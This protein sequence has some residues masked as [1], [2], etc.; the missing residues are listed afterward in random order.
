MA[1]SLQSKIV[2][3]PRFELELDE[4]EEIQL[5]G[6]RHW[7]ELVQSS[8]LFLVGFL[9][10]GGLALYRSVG[11][12]FIAPNVAEPGQWDLFSVT[13][14]ALVVVLAFLWYRESNLKVPRKK[15]AVRL[16]PLYGFVIALLLLA[17]WF[18]FFQG[19]R[20]FYIDPVYAQPADIFN[21]IFIAIAAICLIGVGYFFIDWID[22]Y[23]IVTNRRVVYDD[24]QFLVRHIQQQILIDDI[25]QVNL[26]ADTYPAYWLG[27]GSIIVRSFSPDTLTFQYASKAKAIQN[28][29]QTQLN[30]LRKQQEP[31]TLRRLLK[32]QVYGDKTYKLPT[33]SIYVSERRGPIPGL[34]PPNPQIDA[35]KGTIVWRP[36]WVF[37]LIELLRPIGALVLAIFALVIASQ[38]GLLTSG[39]AVTVGLVA[40]LAIVAWGWWVREEWINDVYI[41]TRQDI[42]DVDR[43]PL[44]PENR[45]RAPLGAIQ[46]ISFDVSFIEQLLGFGT[47]VVKTGGAAGGSFTFNH[48]PD[49]R[50]VQATIYDYLTE[51]RKRE[52]EKDFQTA[53]Q[54][55]REYHQ[56]RHA[57]GEIVTPE[58][59]DEKIASQVAS[60][61]ASYVDE[62]LEQQVSQAVAEQLAG[63]LRR[64]GRRPGDLGRIIRLRSRR[65]G[66]EE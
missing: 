63:A 42:T 30:N 3:N 27:Y 43:R 11:G 51:F 55:I 36:A 7:I 64:V 57:Q 31:E 39:W 56:L 41:L 47:V 28:A 10:F 13:V 4:G 21:L 40:L 25:Q 22:D 66:P 65:R 48:V 53:L 61:V 49:P 35:E 29:I 59:L 2:A 9:I 12:T 26:R 62:Q 18:H 23:L 58:Q 6:R 5:V 34:V 46:D 60:D 45:R 50:N 8:L 20:V 44:G 52:R 17:F 1:S 37:L 19:G 54:L 32:D 33:P 15:G 38:L 14:V 16:G 24:H